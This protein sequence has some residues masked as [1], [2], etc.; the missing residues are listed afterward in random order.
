[1]KIH[2][3]RV[4]KFYIIIIKKFL[5]YYDCEIL[6]FGYVRCE[7]VASGPHKA[8]S[9]PCDDMLCCPKKIKEIYY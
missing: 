4:S 9:A 8:D 5:H 3:M 2:Q 7:K 1:M 6:R